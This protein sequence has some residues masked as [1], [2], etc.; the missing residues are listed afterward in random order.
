[1][2]KAETFVLRVILVHTRT[3]PDRPRA[4]CVR[5]G[6][7]SQKQDKLLVRFALLG[8]PKVLKVATSVQNAVR[9]RT[10]ITQ[11][12]PPVNYVQLGC[13]KQTLGRLVVYHVKQEP[14]KVLKVV[15]FV[16]NAAQ[17]HINL[18]VARQATPFVQWG[19]TRRPWD[20]PRV[21]RALPGHTKTLPGKQRANP[22]NLEPIKVN[23]NKLVVYP[24]QR[25]GTK[26]K[27]GNL[28]A[29]CALEILSVST[30]PRQ[31][32]STWPQFNIHT[33]H[34]KSGS[35]I[36]RFRPV[37]STVWIWDPVVLE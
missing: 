23:G 26:I 2:T 16:R 32:V 27:R 12:K 35:D 10:K 13:T 15:L 37:N 3:T 21:H 29:N 33:V 31:R 28:L 11:G 5:Q 20:R 14:I 34:L 9:D 6:S 8:P 17:E 25:I 36:R 22:V 18:T 19:H 24:V 30:R 7:T 1:M 4:Y